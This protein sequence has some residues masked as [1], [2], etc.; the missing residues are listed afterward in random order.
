M[1][2]EAQ[3]VVL[4]SSELALGVSTYGAW[5]S[6]LSTLEGSN[7]LAT[8]DWPSPTITNSGGSYGSSSADFHADYQG[9]WH[10]LFPNAGYEC[11]VLK[12][13]LPFHG[14]VARQVWNIEERSNH[15]ITL[16]TDSRLPLTITRTIE[17]QA[18][19]VRIQDHVQNN[20]PLPIPFLLGHHP[21]FPFSGRLKL[22]LPGGTVNEISYSGP[23]LQMN[24]E[25]NLTQGLL[26]N[27]AAQEGVPFQGLFTIS[28]FSQGWFA[29]RGM[30]GNKAVGVVWESEDLPHMWLWIENRT[31]EFP[32]FGRSQYI[33][34]EPHRASTPNGLAR[35]IEL[36]ENLEVAPNQSKL[37]WI[38]LFV[39][40]DTPEPVRRV[41]QGG[42]P[43]W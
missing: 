18:D 19:R 11:E 5:I 16:S 27:F 42:G 9:G 6:H 37:L 40:E 10:L 13:P 35:S 30:Q 20:S 43:E 7:L 17:L 22:D 31:P 36:S 14:E 29:L 12:T 23:K 1:T 3:F 39:F 32:W 2:K 38:E 41:R 26:E 4:R 33:G 25:G 28:D 8:R 21:V 34:V 24:P 15:S